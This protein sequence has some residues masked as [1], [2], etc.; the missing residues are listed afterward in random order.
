MR[1]STIPAR[2]SQS[3]SLAVA[4]ALREPQ[5][6]A[7]AGSGARPFRHFDL[8]QPLCGKAGHLSQKI[9]IDALFQ[10][11]AKVHHIVRHRKVPRFE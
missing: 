4:V 6:T 9:G 8:H 1:S 5:R 2:V 7:L 11:R 10:E 3:R